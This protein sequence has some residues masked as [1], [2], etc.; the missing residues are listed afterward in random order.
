MK[1][2]ATWNYDAQKNIINYSSGDTLKEYWFCYKYFQYN[3]LNDI[4]LEYSNSE[5]DGR[6][7]LV[8]NYSYVYDAQKNWT[9]KNIR[10][11]NHIDFDWVTD[12]VDA[13]RRL[14]EIEYY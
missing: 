10:V 5:N 1:S 12:R 8:T 4:V 2:E 9:Q 7:R 14:Q 3:D 13:Y 11:Q 6:N